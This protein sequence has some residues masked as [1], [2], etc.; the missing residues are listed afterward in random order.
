[1]HAWTCGRIW[2]LDEN[3][4]D[5]AALHC[6]HTSLI[7]PSWIS[8][9][10]AASGTVNSGQG[11]TDW[12]VGGGC[13]SVCA[14]LGRLLQDP[15][16]ANVQLQ[17]PGGV[18]IL[19]H[20]AILA[21]TCAWFEAR[22]VRHNSHVRDTQQDTAT[23]A[24]SATDKAPA[25]SASASARPTAST[26]CTTAPTYQFVVD[27]TDQDADTV[28]ALLSYLY[29]GHAQLGPAR[30]TE[31]TAAPDSS[32]GWHTVGKPK[33][34][35]KA[36]AAG[37]PAPSMHQSG[38]SVS[39]GQPPHMLLVRLLHA[40]Q[41]FGVSQLHSECLAKAA[42]LISVECAPAWLIYAHEHGEQELK[43]LALNYVVK[44]YKGGWLGW[45]IA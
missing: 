17:L 25:G 29:T 30:G 37:G 23:A 39:P 36:A 18:V 22:L 35:G 2:V 42:Q 7:P 44:H 21:A 40:A 12:E 31:E 3:G 41:F 32:E 24:G 38:S 16:H 9:A 45:R 34:R 20:S 8:A 43:Q 28:H 4:S 26:T 5:P 13:S 11:E 33:R 27:L 6:I 10:K 1:M 14:S 15:H 19:A